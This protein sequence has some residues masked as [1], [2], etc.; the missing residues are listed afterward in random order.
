MASEYIAWI[1]RFHGTGIATVRKVRI[2]VEKA[3]LL[4]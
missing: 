4:L 3:L 1:C 2:V